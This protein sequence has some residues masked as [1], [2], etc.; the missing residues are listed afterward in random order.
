MTTIRTASLTTALIAAAA[1]GLAACGAS[2][3]EEIRAVVNEFQR[4][5]HKDAEHDCGLLT[6]RAEAQLTAFV[7]GGACE[8]ALGMVEQDEDGPS[9]AEIDKAALRI[10]GDRAVLT[11][12]EAPIGLRK[13]DGDWQIDN[14]F[15][16]SLDER[17]RRLAPQLSEGSDD[18]QVRATL[19]ALSAAY[20]KGDFERACDLFSYGAEAQ[21]YLSLAFASFADT[22]AGA[23][24]PGGRPVPRRIA[25]SSGSSAARTRLPTRRPPPRGST[26]RRCR[27]AETAPPCATRAMGPSS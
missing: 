12:E 19:K 18:R 2:D 27:S 21:L 13:V 16:G 7:G 10:R 1:L 11:L 20:A 5:D 8:K 17:P 22:G 23:E 14:V 25:R 3:E 24:E 26:R 9:K 6:P 15:T 4:S